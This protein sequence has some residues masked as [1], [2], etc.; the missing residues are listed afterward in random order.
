MRRGQV[1]AISM[2]LIAGIIITL[3]GV[4]YFWGKPMIEKR[5]TLTDIANAKSFMIQLDKNIVEVARSGGSKSL[6]IPAISGSS[7]S[8]NDSSDGDGGNEVLFRFFASQAV[9]EMG[10]DASPIPVETY[11]ENPVG[12]YGGSPRIITLAGEKTESGM[13]IMTLRLSYRE[14]D[15]ETPRKRGYKIVLSEDETGENTNTAVIV[16]FSGT[17]TLLQ[18]ADNGGDLTITDIEVRI[19]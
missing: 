16:R 2:V 4:A 1:Q 8:I 15:T 7:L 10:E 3:A 11:D 12:P 19:A 14:L 18:G 5:A 9:I 13:Y 6:S 17:R